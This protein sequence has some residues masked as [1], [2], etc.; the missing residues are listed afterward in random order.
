MGLIYS[1]TA[2]GKTSGAMEQPS[3][4]M[5][6][7]VGA[8][9]RIEKELERLHHQNFVEPACK[10]W[11]EFLKE[12]KGIP[13]LELYE[14]FCG[15]LSTVPRFEGWQEGESR[16]LIDLL[17]ADGGSACAVVTGPEARA[18]SLYASEELHRRPFYEFHPLALT[19]HRSAAIS[20]WASLPW[21]Q[22]CFSSDAA[23]AESSSVSD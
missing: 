12:A 1:S 18:L 16:G 23:P 5:D 17:G 10:L 6:S 21:I 14:R 20:D 11:K 19:H 7:V 22:V 4:A 13:Q 3:G 8:K 9:E 15:T 2:E